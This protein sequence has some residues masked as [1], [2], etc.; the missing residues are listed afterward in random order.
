MDDLRE[1]NNEELFELYEKVEDEL[2]KLNSSK[3][4]YVYSQRLKVVSVCIFWS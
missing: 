1:Y 3:K 4:E 2:K